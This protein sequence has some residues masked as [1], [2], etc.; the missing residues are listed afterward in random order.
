MDVNALAIATLTVQKKG[1][2]G[3]MV[4]ADTEEHGRVLCYL[5]KLYFGDRSV[6]FISDGWIYDA[7]LY[8]D[9]K[10]LVAGTVH[11]VIQLTSLVHLCTAMK[12]QD[13]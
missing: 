2:N 9:D 10:N 12:E 13:T 11:R 8:G 4:V 6:V 1:G 3:D 7:I 5:K